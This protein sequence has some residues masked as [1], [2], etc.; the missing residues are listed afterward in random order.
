MLCSLDELVAF[1]DAYPLVPAIPWLQAAMVILSRVVPLSCG[2]PSGMVENLS[3]M[4][5]LMELFC[6]VEHRSSLLG[7]NARSEVHRSLMQEA[8]SLAHGRKRS[9][10]K[11]RVKDTAPMA[12]KIGPIVHRYSGE[13]LLRPK[14]CRVKVD[15]DESA[16]NLRAIV[17][18]CNGIQREQTMPWVVHQLTLLHSHAEEFAGHS[19]STDCMAGWHSASSLA[20]AML[21]VQNHSVG[22]PLVGDK[23]QHAM[24]A[25]SSANY[26][27]AA[28]VS[29]RGGKFLEK[30]MP[31]SPG[32]S[33]HGGSYGQ[34]IT[35]ALAVTAPAPAAGTAIRLRGAISWNRNASFVGLH[36]KSL[37]PHEGLSMDVCGKAASRRSVPLDNG[38][39]E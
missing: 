27:S 10:A 16:A 13:V 38:E 23:Y 33:P 35:R 31:D 21:Y 39:R 28:K 32:L 11:G 22:A 17:W 29:A 24:E 36:G 2:T 37:R 1:A 20:K 19:L 34:C 26:L 14:T 9:H 25:A 3:G 30:T 5:S 15:A 4:Q 6:D 8:L 7:E 18:Q 12:A